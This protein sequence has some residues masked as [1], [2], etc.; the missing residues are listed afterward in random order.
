MSKTNKRKAQEISPEKSCS[1]KKEHK[2]S[3]QKK[4]ILEPTVNHELKA[5][6]LSQTL[7]MIIR[8][9]ISAKFVQLVK[10]S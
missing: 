6:Y 2:Q 10:V 5:P 7:Y 8:E 1:Q 4:S 9:V 3:N